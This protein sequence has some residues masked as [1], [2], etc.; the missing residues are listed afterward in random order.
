ML[1]LNVKDYIFDSSNKKK[2]MKKITAY[3]ISD[4]SIFEKKETAIARERLLLLTNE[5]ETLFEDS[6]GTI[7]KEDLIFL[8]IE[9]RSELLRIL[10]LEVAEIDNTPRAY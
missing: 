3:K 8:I 2:Q 9:K 10:Q 7:L 5:L 6:D 1:T 4:G